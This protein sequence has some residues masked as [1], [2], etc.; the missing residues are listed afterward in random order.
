[1]KAGSYIKCYVAQYN[2]WIVDCFLSSS[3]G[4][5]VYWERLICFTL[6]SGVCACVISNA[7]PVVKK[8]AWQTMASKKLYEPAARFAHVSSL[9]E[10]KAYVWGGVTQE[11]VPGSKNAKAIK[12]IER[13]DPYLE[14]WSQLNTAGTPHPGLRLAA[15]ASSGEHVYMYGGFSKGGFEGCLSCLN[16]KTLTWS[17]LSPW[18]EGGTAGGPMRKADCGMVHFHLNKLAVIGGS[19]IPTGPTQPGSSLFRHTPAIDGRGSTNEF[20]VFDLSQGTRM[21]IDSLT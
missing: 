10:G 7:V 21:T 6:Y 19:G 8:W 5:E 15:C 9:A 3:K 16:V 17:R 4:T 13:F 14:V 12:C 18:P 1:M 11:L 2:S 20:H